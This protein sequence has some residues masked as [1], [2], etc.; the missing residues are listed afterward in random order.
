MS[1]M[2]TVYLSTAL[3]ARSKALHNKGVSVRCVKQ[4]RTRI[5]FP[6]MIS[7][8]GMRGM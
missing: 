1:N 4:M 3:G 6:E 7:W 8:Y 2:D 5:S